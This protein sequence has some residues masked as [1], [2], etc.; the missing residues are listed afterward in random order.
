MITC[1]ARHLTRKQ[2][3]SPRLTESLALLQLK[4]LHIKHT[5]GAKR[6][7]DWH[8]MRHKTNRLRLHNIYIQWQQLKDME[9]QAIG[10]KQ[11]KTYK[12]KNSS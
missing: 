12:T 8:I 6:N 3:S 7:Y 10:D 11:T 4:A 5:M 2:A 1:I 9:S